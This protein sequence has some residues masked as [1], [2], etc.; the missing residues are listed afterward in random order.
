MEKKLGDA[1]KATNM[2]EQALSNSSTAALVCSLGEILVANGDVK[3]ARDLYARHLLRL[4]TEKDI[5]E[6][7]LASAWLEERYFKNFDR[8]QELL[9]SAL[10]LSPGSSLANV[11]LARLEGRIQRRNNKNDHSG[12]KATAKRLAN[13]CNEIQKGKQRPSDPTDGRVFNAL[14]NLEVKSRRYSTAREILKRGMDMYPQD[15][16]VSIS[17]LLLLLCGCCC[18]V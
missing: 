7:Y 15:H 9:H 6:V 10:A 17:S 14:A 12:N 2:F 16:A 8:A 3:R 18:S 11:A 13:V 4:K 5:V 1:A